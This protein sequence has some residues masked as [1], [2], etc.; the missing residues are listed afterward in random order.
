MVRSWVHRR[1]VGILVV[2][3]GLL[4]FAPAAAQQADEYDITIARVIRLLPRPPE[5]VV[6]IDADISGRSLHDKLQH[7]EGFVIRGE[8]V[9]HLVRQSDTLQRALKGP[10]IFDYALAITIWHE[11]AHIDGA[12][13]AKARRAEEQ[14][15][16]EFV[17]TGR[18]E[19][20]R[21]MKYLALLKNRP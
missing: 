9:V 14:L 16:T 10:G 5:K 3:A 8:R 2:S 20:V 4:G 12:D 19:R 1:L 13:E 17:L 21:G 18:V 15:W 6:V 11:M 7:V